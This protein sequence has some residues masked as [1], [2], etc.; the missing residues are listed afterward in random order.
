VKRFSTWLVSA[1]PKYSALRT[2]LD[3]KLQTADAVYRGA[4][5][6]QL[7]PRT[8][9]MVTVPLAQA[10]GGARLDAKD[11]VKNLGDLLQT[12]IVAY[13]AE[14]VGPTYEKLGSLAAQQALS[15]EWD[16][17]LHAGARV[18][19]IKGFIKELDEFA[20]HYSLKKGPD[21]LWEVYPLSTPQA[22]G[23]GDAFIPEIG[24]GF[25]DS[26]K[27]PE[28]EYLP[29]RG[30]IKV[31]PASASDF[32]KGAPG[33]AWIGLL[34]ISERT[35]GGPHE[36]FLI[37]ALHMEKHLSLPHNGD[38]DPVE[39][40]GASGHHES[41]V[42]CIGQGRIKTDKWHRTKYNPDGKMKDIK[43]CTWIGCVMGFAMVKAYNAIGHQWA[44]TSGTLQPT[45][46]AKYKLG[47]DNL[48]DI[49]V[50]GDEW[51]I[52]GSWAEGIWRATKDMKGNIDIRIG[53]FKDPTAKP[54]KPIPVAPKA[55]AV[56]AKAPGKQINLRLGTP[57]VSQGK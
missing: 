30:P 25:T 37:P 19:D 51:N 21:Q 57:Q 32:E 9:Q 13:W 54:A 41:L 11:K 45:A 3:N 39:Q 1:K 55:P 17:L 36:L 34:T 31:E 40:W 23:E 46:T 12:A 47:A 15:I 8:N 28:R 7:D 48:Y 5:V 10:R 35:G 4:S 22:G 50:K 18:A 26:Y 33:S 56:A 16:K 29:F 14:V 20:K 43:N 24:K 44:F 52:P 49:E 6:Q 2:E 38:V 27:K 53:G 42:C